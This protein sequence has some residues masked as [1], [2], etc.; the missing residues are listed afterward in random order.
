[1]RIYRG[2]L[3]DFENPWEKLNYER[4][5]FEDQ[6]RLYAAQRE[7]RRSLC[8]HEA[9]HAVIAYR[10]GGTVE[11]VHVV[12]TGKHAGECYWRLAENDPFKRIVFMLAGEASDR[13]LFNTEPR[14]FK[15]PWEPDENGQ[16]LQGLF[17]T[18]DRV[19]AYR[20]A[21]KIEGNVDDTMLR[22]WKQATELV[23]GER[24]TIKA[25]AE[26]LD[27]KGDLD[28]PTV[29]SFLHECDKEEERRL[30]RIKQRM[31][32]KKKARPAEVTH[33]RTD[34]YI[35]GTPEYRAARQAMYDRAAAEFWSRERAR[36]R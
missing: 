24:D 3:I 7:S 28:G 34:G 21:A 11:R 22:A 20:E 12:G 15:N 36:Y 13:I 8:A 35:R 33:H 5:E 17:R 9:S 10:L 2:G 1:M 19:E 32:N 27:R 4:R 23:S 18:T 16:L 30:E 14:E 29:M 6:A 26:L 31:R 25:L